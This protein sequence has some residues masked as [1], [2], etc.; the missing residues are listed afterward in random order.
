M[1]VSILI[2]TACFDHPL[3]I[4]PKVTEPKWVSKN[5]RS[6]K[7]YISLPGLWRNYYDII[8]YHRDARTGELWLTPTLLD[9]MEHRM[10]NAFYMSPEGD[11]AISCVESG[12]RFQ[13]RKIFFKPDRPLAVSSLYLSD[14]YGDHVSVTVN[15]KPY[16]AERVGEGYS[17][18]LKI[19]LN[20]KV[21]TDG[22]RIIVEGDAGAPAPALPQKPGTVISDSTEAQGKVIDAFSTVEA[23]EADRLV[24]T[25]VKDGYVT[26][27]N[28]FD[29]IQFNNVDFGSGGAVEFLARVASSVSGSSIEIAL[30]DVSADAIGKCLIPH[31]GG[32]RKWQEVS[33]RVEKITGV[34]DVILRFFGTTQENLF[35]LDWIKF[36]TEA[37][38]Q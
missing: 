7:Q 37:S 38:G 30:D 32:D 2:V 10:A 16:T 1:N 3:N 9:A 35:N 20:R 18:E 33:C 12:T 6:G 36:S 34:H 24:G 27:C 26:S 31:T 28:N 29:Y 4:L 5:Y 13:D 15:G 11:G 22:L 17:R 25:T 23:E 14:L 8:G 21:G 19:V